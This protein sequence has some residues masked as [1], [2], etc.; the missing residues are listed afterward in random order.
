MIIQEQKIQRFKKKK[1]DHDEIKNEDTE[2]KKENLDE[3]PKVV[4]NPKKKVLLV[5]KKKEPEK[6]PEKKPKPV[7]DSNEPQKKPKTVRDSNER[8]P[9]QYKIP[10]F[11]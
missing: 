9:G 1:K 3:S 7:R 11:Q 4:E 8:Y 10:D 5:K 6:K 2:L